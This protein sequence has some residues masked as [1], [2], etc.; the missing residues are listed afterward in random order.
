MSEPDEPDTTTDVSYTQI[1]DALFL[2]YV[3]WLHG[4]DQALVDALADAAVPPVS[5]TDS[6]QPPL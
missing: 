4:S 1:Y 3:Q 6:A 5:D 2:E